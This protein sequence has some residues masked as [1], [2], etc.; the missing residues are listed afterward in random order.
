[1]ESSSRAAANGNPSHQLVQETP[2]QDA[3][4]A[5]ARA[6]DAALRTQS[7]SGRGTERRPRSATGRGNG[8]ATGRDNG[9]GA[10]GGGAT[11]HVT[12]IPSNGESPATTESFT[13]VTNVDSVDFSLSLSQTARDSHASSFSI[14]E[15]DSSGDENSS[16]T[17]RER[18]HKIKRLEEHVEALKVEANI[19]KKN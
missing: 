8:H 9:V 7:A 15:G 12:Y 10:L 17:A 19:A 18:R 3:V 14:G 16:N 5:T 1:M 4:P 11:T 13:V 2:T 6:Q